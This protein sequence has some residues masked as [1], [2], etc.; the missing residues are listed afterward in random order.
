MGLYDETLKG[1]L[2][3]KSIKQEGGFIGVPYPFKRLCE[4]LPVMEKGHSIGLLGPTGSGKSRLARFIFVYHVYRFY[5]ET[6]YPVRIVFLSLEDN[7]EKVMKSVIVHYLKEYHNISITLQELD[8]KTEE[9]SDKVVD[10]LIEAHKYFEEFEKIVSIIDGLNTPN[11][12]LNLCKGIALKLGRVRKYKV[13]VEGEIVE[14][15]KYESDVHVFCVADNMSN[16]DV[17]KAGENEQQ[18]I[19]SFAK[20]VVR[21]KLCNFFGWTV[22]QILQMD[23]QSERQQYTSSGSTIVSKLEPSLASVGDSKRATRTMHVI[24]SLFNPSRY[25]LIHYPIPPKND[26]DNCYRIDLLGNRFRSLRILKS[27]DSDVGMRIPLIF[28]G[29][30]EI[31]TEAPLPK[32]PELKN[33][34]ESLTGKKYTSNINNLTFGSSD[35]YDGDD[36]DPF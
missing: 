36:E 35:E 16:I 11:E 25:E 4:Y 7:K 33:L 15:H 31:F 9:L 10:A 2:K 26:V 24:L 13:E 21:E 30:S 20:E 12:I 5:K 18:A 1:I 28:N 32:T 23:F 29:I 22:I 8:S 3:N 17:E 19:Y 34:Y 14:Q 6:G 27:N